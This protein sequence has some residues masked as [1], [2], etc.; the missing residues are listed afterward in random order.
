MIEIDD[1]DRRR[2]ILGQL[3]AIEKYVSIAFENQ[4]ISATP[5][6]DVER[7][8]AS[9]KTS[10]V[11]FFHFSFSDVQKELFKKAEIVVLSVA[12]PRYTYST[13][14]NKETKKILEEDL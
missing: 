11:H 10:A 1:M 12:H 5:E 9:G 6:E 3:G 13:V 4:V 2:M 7:T 8:N 14:L